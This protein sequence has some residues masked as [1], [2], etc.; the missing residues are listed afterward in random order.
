ME[1][2]KGDVDKAKSF[3]VKVE[4]AMNAAAAQVMRSAAARKT[5]RTHVKAV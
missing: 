2:Q 1:V 5:A 3:A 4:Q